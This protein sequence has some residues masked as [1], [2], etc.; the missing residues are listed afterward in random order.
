MRGALQVGGMLLG[1]LGRDLSDHAVQPLFHALEVG[2]SVLRVELGLFLQMTNRRSTQLLLVL[3]IKC[4]QLLLDFSFA[5]IFSQLQL[6]CVASKKGLLLRLQ[7][8]QRDLQFLG[9][10]FTN[11]ILLELMLCRKS[12]LV[13]F[14][15]LLERRL[16]LGVV[17]L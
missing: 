12:G 3:R 1:E 8:S 10:L 6:F 2:G 17:I 7:F 5:A 13:G 14:V 16:A 9:S 11:R 15:T 4:R